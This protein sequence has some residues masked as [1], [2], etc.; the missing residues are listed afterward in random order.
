MP[1]RL[2]GLAGPHRFSRYALGFRITASGEGTEV[3]AVS[4]GDFPGLHGLAYRTVVV[5]S[6]GHVFALRRMLQQISSRALI[7]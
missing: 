6:G 5:G 3:A 4:Y 1:E 7:N 2:L